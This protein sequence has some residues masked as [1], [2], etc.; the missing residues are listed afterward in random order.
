MLFQLAALVCRVIVE[1]RLVAAGVFAEGAKDLSYLVVPP[2]LLVLAFPILQRNARPLLQRLRP[3]HLALRVVLIS[4]GLGICLRLVYWGGVVTAT[5]FGMV[6]NDEPAAAAGPMFHFGC[7]Q[8]GWMALGLLVTVVLMPLVEET[9]NRGLILSTLLRKGEAPAIAVSSAWFA[10]LHAS[11]TIPLA[12]VF[13]ILAGLLYI[14][15]RSLLAPLLAHAT[16]NALTI[17][18]W[19]CLSGTWNPVEYTQTTAAVGTL[20]LGLLVT[21]LLSGWLLVTEGAVGARCAPRR[22]PDPGSQSVRDPLDDV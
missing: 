16:Y 15:S 11:T 3:Q 9:T 21:A 6:R 1:Q 5:S 14:N 2:V 13:G 17:L 18:D 4:V 7:P 22:R 20:G 10:L 19:R 8:A 12:F